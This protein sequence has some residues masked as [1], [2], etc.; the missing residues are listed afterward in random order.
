MPHTYDPKAGKHQTPSSL[1]LLEPMGGII[2]EAPALKS[3]GNKPLQMSFEE[4]LKALTFFHLEEHTSGAHLVQVL[5]E[6]AFARA[7]IAPGE[8]LLL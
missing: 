7:E 8:E 3:R 2:P 5:E 1:K 4:Q 6:D